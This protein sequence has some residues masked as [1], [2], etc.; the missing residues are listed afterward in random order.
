MKRV[1]TLT[2]LLCASLAVVSAAGK[3]KAESAPVIGE[4]WSEEKANAWYAEKEWPVG[5]VFVPS[6]AGTPVELWGAE[7]FDG[8][9]G[10]L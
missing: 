4:R 2:A 3:K 1:L 5:C 6:Y 7:Y 9:A 10:R 8:S